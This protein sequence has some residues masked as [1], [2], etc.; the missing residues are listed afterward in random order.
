MKTGRTLIIANEM[1]IHG[2]KM[3]YVVIIEK[4]L[5]FMT[6]T[7]DY[8]VCSSEESNDLDTLSIDKLQSSLLVYE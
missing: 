2:E 7:Y 8:V 3:D 4:I 6:L 5:R 1:R